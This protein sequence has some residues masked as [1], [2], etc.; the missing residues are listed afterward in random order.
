M[1]A[2]GAEGLLE[3]VNALLARRQEELAYSRKQEEDLRAQIANISHDLR[4]PL[5][6]IL[7]YLQLLET[8][9]DP[10]KAGKSISR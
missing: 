4:T 3:E 10:E 5:T 1:P 2:G 9:P 7:G 8:E 6:A